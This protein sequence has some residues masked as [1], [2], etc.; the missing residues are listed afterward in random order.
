M[1]IFSELDKEVMADFARKALRA[2]VFREPVPSGR[3]SSLSFPDYAG[4]FVTLYHDNQLRGCI[5]ILDESLPC[6]EA[7]IIAAQKSALQDYRFEPISKNE[8]R[9]LV[10]EVS[11]LSPPERITS[12][13]QIQIGEHGLIIELRGSRGLLLPQ[14]ASERKWTPERFLSAVCEKA[15]LPASALNDPEVKLFR[16]S[17]S[18]FSF[19]FA[20]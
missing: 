12:S 6:I 7:I 5:G 20:E 15:S 16:F 1:I 14:V 11:I 18:R 8:L 2:A 13:D 9:D 4:A 3:N 17:G 19:S 10:I